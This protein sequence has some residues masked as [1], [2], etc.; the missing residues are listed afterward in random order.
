MGLPELFLAVLV[1]G[2]SCVNTGVPAAA[3]LRSRDGRFLVVAA[4]NG[5]LALLGALWTWGEL[6]LDPPSWSVPNLPVLGLALLVA[7]L[8]LAT[9]LW[10]RHV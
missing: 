5:V 3:F 4:A 8:F 10:P 2:I 9:S 7:V 6:P 1:A